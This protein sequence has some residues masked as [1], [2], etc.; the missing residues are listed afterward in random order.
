MC[1]L[2]LLCDVSYLPLA[3]YLPNINDTR[4][5]RPQLL[6][7]RALATVATARNPAGVRTT[8]ALSPAV[9]SALNTALVLAPIAVICYGWGQ[10]VTNPGAGLPQRGGSS[11]NPVAEPL[12]VIRGGKV[13]RLLIARPLPSRRRHSHPTPCCIPYQVAA[14][15]TQPVDGARGW[16]PPLHHRSCAHAGTSLR[17]AALHLHPPLHPPPFRCLSET[18]ASKQPPPPSC[19]HLGLLLGR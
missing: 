3:P 15:M 7:D 16:Y 10:G 8:M 9:R 1:C 4:A 19:T 2:N 14:T 12:V 13:G 6:G 5:I 11:I 17:L 18:R